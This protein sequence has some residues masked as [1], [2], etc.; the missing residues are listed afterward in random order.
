MAEDILQK[1]LAGLSV[2]P[3]VSAFGRD[4]RGAFSVRVVVTARELERWRSAVSAWVQ[5]QD[6][7]D[8]IATQLCFTDV[9]AGIELAVALLENLHARAARDDEHARA[10]SVVRRLCSGEAVD[11]ADLQRARAVSSAVVARCQAAAP[12]GDGASYFAEA[13]LGLLDGCLCVDDPKKRA[14]LVYSGV[15]DAMQAA[16]NFDLGDFDDAHHRTSGLFTV[17][18]RCVEQLFSTSLRR[19]NALTS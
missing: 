9:G 1:F 13:V 16:A 3:E 5:T 15:S 4:A 11:E 8:T 19:A 14:S 17:L 12:C 18:E 10:L 7:I 6:Y 2:R